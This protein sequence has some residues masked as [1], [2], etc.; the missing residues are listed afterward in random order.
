MSY[1]RAESEVIRSMLSAYG[2]PATIQGNHFAEVQPHLLVAMDGLRVEVPVLAQSEALQLIGDVPS[3]ATLPESRAFR[4]RWIVS[5]I[6][7]ALSL[8]VG[9][10]CPAWLHWRSEVSE[11]AKAPS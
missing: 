9:L 8:F 6:F 5:S 7:F 4:S 3:A 2:I 10:P 11:E 1:S